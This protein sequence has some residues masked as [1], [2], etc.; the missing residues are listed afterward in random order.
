MQKKAG[1]FKG[2][3]LQI[4]AAFWYGDGTKI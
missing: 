1:N 2:K 4:T 3:V